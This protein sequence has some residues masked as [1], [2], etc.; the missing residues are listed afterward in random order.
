[1]T[2]TKNKKRNIIPLLIGRENLENPMR[3]TRNVSKT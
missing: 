3:T 2:M 1:M